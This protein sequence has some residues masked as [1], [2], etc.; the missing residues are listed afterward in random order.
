T[1]EQFI[2][3]AHGSPYRLARCCSLYWVER[4]KGDK[5]MV[6]FQNLPKGKRSRDS[7]MSG[8]ASCESLVEDARVSVP[9]LPKN[10]YSWVTLP[11]VP[12]ALS[13]GR[14]YRT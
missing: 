11:A 2:Q 9:R 3:K 12:Q 10:T 13:Y 6:L 7:A 1:A 4:G 8:L 5:L 14:I